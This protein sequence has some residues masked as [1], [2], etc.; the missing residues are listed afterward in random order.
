LIGRD[1]NPGFYADTQNTI[2]EGFRE[3]FADIFEVRTKFYFLEHLGLVEPLVGSG[4]GGDAIR[5]FVKVGFNFIVYG[6]RF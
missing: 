3:A 2:G 5:S 4:D 1:F 6:R